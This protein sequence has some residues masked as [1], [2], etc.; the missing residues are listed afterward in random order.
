VVESE[1]STGG[2]GTSPGTSSQ[3]DHQS[4]GTIT[5][6]ASQVE[7]GESFEITV[8]GSDSDGVDYVGY[9]LDGNKS[10][11]AWSTKGKSSYTWTINFN[12]P[13]THTFSG[14]VAGRIAGQVNSLSV[15]TSPK[16]V[17]VTVVESETSTGGTGAETSVSPQWREDSPTTSS[18]SVSKTNVLLGEKF[19]ITIE[20]QDADGIQGIWLHDMDYNKYDR[21]ACPLIEY[22]EDSS[23]EDGFMVV[24]RSKNTRGVYRFQGKIK[25]KAPNSS[26][27]VDSLTEIITVDVRGEFWDSSEDTSPSV[28]MSIM[29]DDDY[30]QSENVF[31]QNENFIIYARGED[32]D[33]LGKLI[34]KYR[35]GNCSGEKFPFREEI[36]DDGTVKEAWYRIKLDDPGIHY[37]Q[38]QADG[39][40]LGY[41]EGLSRSYRYAQTR[42]TP[43]N[44]IASGSIYQTPV[45]NASGT[46]KV[47]EDKDFVKPGE[48]IQITVTGKDP[49]GVKALGI[50]EDGKTDYWS[51][52]GATSFT[53]SFSYSQTGFHN[54]K[55]MIE[56]FYS[57]G[58]R[59][60]EEKYADP[61]GGVIVQVTNEPP[62][63][64][65][66]DHPT[67]GKI[68]SY[69]KTSILPS[70]E[71]GITIEG[72]D[73]DGVEAVGLQE[74]NGRIKWFSA[75]KHTWFLEKNKEG[76]YLFYG[77]VKGK[78]PTVPWWKFWAS[79]TTQVRTM[80]QACKVEISNKNRPASGTLEASALT[81]KRGEPYTITMKGEDPDGL[82]FSKLYVYWDGHSLGEK[83]I[84]E[85]ETESTFKKTWTFSQERAGTYE[86]AGK[87]EG[88][89]P[90]G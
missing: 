68:L 60:V 2:T 89:K 29:K 25:G 90:D 28:S 31:D 45:S 62:K 57:G 80:P 87:V 44:I 70:E 13:G 14:M 74:G 30:G 50:Q 15:W 37:F 17:T 38:A 76:E 11:P 8:Q 65:A 59:E 20:A 66:I 5:A 40:I 26:R 35:H 85:K 18:I 63:S 86:Y 67:S 6:S 54:Y 75:K 19:E 56:G 12:Q 72:E 69:P 84:M 48:T 83:D 23:P 27:G 21:N 24:H 88:K 9:V 64:S 61:E 10:Q 46:I 71:F 16:S 77:Y 7:V 49:E 73:I 47:E 52:P 1:T 55:G 42:L 22:T 78:N 39:F 82:W 81:V 79:R 34:V 43:V 51:K 58:R 4:T 3:T 41:P 36:S 32:P 53:R 33:G